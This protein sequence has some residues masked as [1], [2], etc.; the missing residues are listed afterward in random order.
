[1][2]LGGINSWDKWRHNVVD[3]GSNV[4]DR[5]SSIPTNFPTRRYERGGTN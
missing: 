4:N 2:S 1:M 5:W 3:S